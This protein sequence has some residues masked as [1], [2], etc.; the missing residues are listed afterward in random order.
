MSRATAITDDTLV[1]VITTCRLGDVDL[2]QDSPAWDA[3]GLRQELADT[4]CALLHDIDG[5]PV[6]IEIVRPRADASAA[7]T[8]H[9]RGRVNDS[10][11]RL[12]KQLQNSAPVA[13]VGAEIALLLE[14]LS[15]LYGPELLAAIGRHQIERSLVALGRCPYH[16]D[17]VRTRS[18]PCQRCADEHREFA[19]VMAEVFGGE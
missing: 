8:K 18:E 11:G 4:G 19:A 16:A 15:F 10:Y 7:W 9:V 13:M 12:G 17:Q 3:A 14:R 6:V 2:L 5:E 1:R